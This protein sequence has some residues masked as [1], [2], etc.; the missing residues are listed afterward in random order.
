MFSS[1][2]ESSIIADVEAEFDVEKDFPEFLSSVLD[3]K[4][5]CIHNNE[6]NIND[7][8]AK[9]VRSSRSNC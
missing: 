3:R 2:L 9:S 1:G 5:Q 4:E 8:Q 6:T 7:L